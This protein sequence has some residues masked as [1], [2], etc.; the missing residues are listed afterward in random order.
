MIL[1]SPLGDDAYA[2]RAAHVLATRLTAG[3]HDAE[4][5]IRD[6]A[7]EPPPHIGAAFVEAISTPPPEQTPA[8][9]RELA[10][11]DDF[12]AEI[13]AADQ[14]I[15]ATPM[16]NFGPPTTLKAWFDHVLGPAVRWS[17][18]RDPRMRR[19][20]GRKVYLIEARVPIS[21]GGPTSMQDFQEPHIR[22]MLG[23]MGIDDVEIIAMD[24]L[25]QEPDVALKIF[26]DSLR[27]ISRRFR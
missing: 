7:A 24:C 26:D 17:G 3:R 20:P 8:H 18:E 4:I 14:I 13:A 19:F 11:S 5:T 23:L 9:R 21:G 15:I 1:A 2:N 6:L 10:L 16:I 12:A 22:A 25:V 27:E